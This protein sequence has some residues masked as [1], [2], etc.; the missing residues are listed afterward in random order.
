MTM[1]SAG[2][3]ALIGLSGSGKSSL[4]RLAAL[5]AG[6][7]FV[8]LDLV[9]ERELGMSIP[10]IF[11]GRGERFFRDAETNAMRDALLSPKRSLIATGG[12]IVLRPENLRLL[13]ENAFLV[14]L[15]RPVDAIAKDLAND[16][17]RPLVTGPEKLY[18]MER[19]RRP[20]YLEAADA[21]LQNEAD[22]SEVLDALVALLTPI[23]SGY[24][25]IG[26]PIA[27]TLSPAIHGIVFETLGIEETYG[28]LRVPRGELQ[29]F[30]ENV[31][32]SSVRGF[33]I[34]HPHKRDVIPFLDEIEEEARLC[35]AVN[36]VLVREGRLSGF[37]TDMGGL[38]ASLNE[39]GH[40]F[41]GEDVV[42]LGAGGASRSVVFKALQ[43]K[44][45][46]VL[47]LSRRLE[48]AEEVAASARASMASPVVRAGIFSP[49]SMYDAASRASILINATPLG[50]NGI[51]EDFPSLEFLR[52]LPW[53][54]PVCDLVYDPPETNLLRQARKLGHPTL[55]GL[56][57]LIYQA[58]LA[59][60]LF[61]GLNLDRLVL[62]NSI[63]RE[64]ES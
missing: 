44:A 43:E 12:G 40:G 1:R 5:A 9:V 37:N 52:A 15:D 22:F 64:V 39:V 57:M 21:V 6:L 55:N 32:G 60:E 61:L 41:F 25:V 27:Q 17:S 10:R 59:D 47:V 58:I 36:T 63:R 34:T 49:K 53:G 45:A 7:P 56:G 14:F 31:R 51:G 33:N 19:E 46:S 29:N 54:A 48:K 4:G 16:D 42:V 30:L 3:I 35:G 62:K 18:R 26:D 20:L 2:H 8:D 28:A 24:L 38:L 13:R 50:M 23:R 11:E